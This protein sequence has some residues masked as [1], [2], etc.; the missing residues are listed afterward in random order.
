[1]R[2]AVAELIALHRSVG[3]VPE[4]REKALTVKTT[5]ISKFLPEPVKVIE[6][7]KKLSQV[8]EIMKIQ[9]NKNNLKPKIKTFQHMAGD[10]LVL[11]LMEKVRKIMFKTQSVNKIFNILFRPR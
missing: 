10:E 7:I 3:I 9:N 6:F 8:R 11:K 2:K 5:S 4:E 1:M